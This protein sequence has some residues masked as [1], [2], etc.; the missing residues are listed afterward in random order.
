[1]INF[2]FTEHVKLA[3]KG[4][5]PNDIAELSALDENKFSKEDILTLVGSG[6]K[7]H[8]IKKLIE[9]FETTDDNK[10]GEQDNNEPEK[11]GDNEQTQDDPDV[12]DDPD[13]SVDYKSLYEKEKKLRQK[14]QQKTV[15]SKEGP[16]RTDDKTDEQIALEIAQ[17]VL[18]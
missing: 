12:S 15:K 3:T 4:F 8:D 2:S 11:P 13:D 14:L 18:S 16:E 1:M 7:L 17:D 6:Y 9:T 5:K 10:N